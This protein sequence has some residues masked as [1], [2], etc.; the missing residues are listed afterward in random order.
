MKDL[1]SK[2]VIRLWADVQSKFRFSVVDKNKS[3]VMHLVG[4]F[5]QLIGVQDRKYFMSR[6]AVTF[7]DKVYIPFVIGSGDRWQLVAQVC[8]L[9]HEAHHVV[10]F[11]K[12]PVKF[13]FRYVVSSTDRAFYE[14][15]AMRAS[16]EMYRYLTGEMM[17]PAYV[18]GRLQA[19]ACK[20]RDINVTQKSLEAVCKTIE[21]GGV[22]TETAQYIIQLM[23]RSEMKVGKLPPMSLWLDNGLF[24]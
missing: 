19:Y 3:S 23:E 22:I 13:P 18:A 2:S 7:R 6:Y 21:K 20:Q 17:D 12:S 9:A 1:D 4:G 10:Q 24:L 14:M 8:N 15:E 16:M 11:R 5:L